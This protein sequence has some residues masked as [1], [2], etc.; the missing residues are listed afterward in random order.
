MAASA[1]SRQLAASAAKLRLKYGQERTREPR[2]H[3]VVSS[4]SIALDWAL[5]V[6]GYE[7]GSLYEITGPPGA[8]KSTAAIAT[9]IEHLSAFPDRGVA[10]IDLERTFDEARA[11]AMGLDCSLEAEDAGRWMHML[12]DSSEHVSDMARDLIVTGL[13]SLVVV[14][15]VGAMESDKTLG[16]TAEKAADAVGRNAKIITQMNKAL[17][18]LAAK[19]KCTVILVN[20]PRAAVGSMSPVDVSAGPKHMQHATT[21]KLEMRA[22][23]T[24]ENVRELRL[25]GET[26]DL[27]VSIKTRIRVPRLKNGLPGRVAEVFLNRVGTPEFGPPGFDLPDEAMSLGTRLKVIKLGGTYYTMPDGQR[28]NGK[29]AA[30]AYLREHPDVVQMVR[31]AIL[32]DAPTDPDDEGEADAS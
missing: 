14:D 26:D 15:S 8:G 1:G 24:A 19:H 27:Q 22:L 28:V 5:R 17:V 12:A 30:L 23:G 11:T 21:G 7:Q 4:G 2:S 10:Y 13:F 25:P 6:G 29:A 20:Q 16:K 9:M 3:I 31:K 18:F 32:F